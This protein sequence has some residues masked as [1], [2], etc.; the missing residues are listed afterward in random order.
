MFGSG[1]D[2]QKRKEGEVDGKEVG[3]EQVESAAVVEERRQ[4]D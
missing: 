3:E 4:Q 2:S 1:A